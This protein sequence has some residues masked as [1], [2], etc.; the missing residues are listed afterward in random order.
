MTIAR[1]LSCFVIFLAA[2]ILS[3]AAEQGTSTIIIRRVTLIDGTGR[4][5]QENVD[6]LI[7]TGQ[8]SSIGPGLPAPE[9]AKSIDAVGKFAIPGLID[10]RVQLGPTPANRVLRGEIT[11]EQRLESLRALLAAGVTTV[12]LIQGDFDEQQLYQRWQ[13]EALII[14]P[15]IIAGG[16]TFAAQNGRRARDYSIMSLAVRDREMRELAD[17]NDARDKA[18]ELAHEGLQVFEIVYDEGSAEDSYPRLSKEAF[19]KVVQEAHGHDRK[20][21][22]EAGSNEEVGTA[23]DLGVDAIE[24]AWVEALTAE[25]LAQMA[26]SQIAFIPALTE[27]GDFLN[28]LDEPALNAYLQEPIVQRTLSSV[29]KESLASKSG[30]LADLRK[31]FA[32]KPEIR[33]LVRQEELR[34][35][36]NVRRAQVAGVKIALGTGSGSVLVFPGAAVHRE[37]QLL[38]KAGVSPMDALVSATR[39]T[40]QT[41]GIGETMGTIEPGKRADMVILDADP[42]A[43]IANTERISEVIQQGKLLKPAELQLN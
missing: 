9:G 31:A 21:F 38:V 40:A 10:A 20:I 8:I 32:Q 37:L 24:A 27:Q 35:Y 28:L 2:S 26:R 23:A 16:P 41:L 17:E 33:A 14:S 5:A 12:R 22:C 39:N 30:Y 36:E 6:I 13:K 25:H 18:R 15:Q 43:D 3:A 34:A 29:M 1:R 4:P 42:L 7:K 11:I 19:A